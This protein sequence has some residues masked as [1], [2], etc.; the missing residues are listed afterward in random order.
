MTATW[1][2]LRRAYREVQPVLSTSVRARPI[3]TRPL[4]GDRRADR[5]CRRAWIRPRVARGAAFFPAVLDNAR[6]ADR[7]RRGG[8]THAQNPDRHGCD[9]PPAAPTVARGG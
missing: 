4:H 5:S 7:G 6:A 2:R 1:S 3:R 9:A 8:A